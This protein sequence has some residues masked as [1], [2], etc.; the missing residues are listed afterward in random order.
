MLARAFPQILGHQ[1]TWTR[2]QRE[3]TVP[4]GTLLFTKQWVQLE[5][6]QSLCLQQQIQKQKLSSFKESKITT[7][8]MFFGAPRPWLKCHQK[9]LNLVTVPSSSAFLIS[10]LL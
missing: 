3:L 10:D 6:T 2:K 8:K 5:G 1:P 4:S 9:G 7:V